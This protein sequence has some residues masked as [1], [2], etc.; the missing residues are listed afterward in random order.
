MRM[1][2]IVSSCMHTYAHRGGGAKKGQRYKIFPNIECRFIADS[3]CYK[4]FAQ[5]AENDILGTV[6]FS[7][8]RL[9]RAVLYCYLNKM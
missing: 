8:S 9:W 5:N 4:M 1:L 3:K 2:F 6:K 7:L